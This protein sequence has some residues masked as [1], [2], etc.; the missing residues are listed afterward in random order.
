MKK[1]NQKTELSKTK[2]RIRQ[3]LLKKSIELRKKLKEINQQIEKL[4]EEK[5]IKFLSKF[6]GNCYQQYTCSGFY[7]RGEK[8]ENNQLVGT[9]ICTY[10]GKKDEKEKVQQIQFNYR[11]HLQMGDSGVK[12]WKKI[13]NIKFDKLIEEVKNLIKSND[14]IQRKK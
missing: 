8:I 9:E 3:N 10:S 7:F 4:D 13:P 5:H 6:L 12:K 2:Y 1:Q 14:E 11:V